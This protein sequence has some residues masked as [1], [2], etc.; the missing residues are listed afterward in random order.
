MARLNCAIV[1]VALAAGLA[2]CG[3]NGNQSGGKSGDATTAASLKAGP[4]RTEGKIETAKLE[5]FSAFLPA[6]LAPWKKLPRLGNYSG[7]TQS[8]TTAT[9]K[10]PEGGASFSIVITFSNT[11]IGQTKGILA[12]PKTAAQWGFE[13]TTFAGYPALAGKPG[14]NMAGTPFVVVL[15][16]SRMVTLMFDPAHGLTLDAIRPVFDKVDFDGI[17]A[18]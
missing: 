15:S 18:K 12:D 8:T 10:K 9:Y 1:V 13:A 5:E 4:D 6:E 16:N 17:A 7:D 14:G 11:I 3:D 2:A